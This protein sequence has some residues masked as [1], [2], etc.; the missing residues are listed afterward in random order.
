M[1]AAALWAM[2]RW[3]F[4]AIGVAVAAVLVAVLVELRAQPGEDALVM[5]ADQKL[6]DAVR[7]GDRSVARRLLSLQFSFVDENGKAYDRK[8]FLSALKGM[9]EASAA[10]V[11]V[12]RYGRVA[13]VT[14]HRHSAHDD[15]VF[16]LDIWAKQKGNWRA[17]LM[18][19][20]APATADAAAGS[21]PSA[22][23]SAAATPYDCK[24]PCQTLPYRVR[25]PAEQDIVNAFQAI[26]KAAIAHDADAW[27]KNVADEFVLYGS[28]RAPIPT[29]A[30][31][32]TIERQKADN[33]A[34]TVGEIETMRL[35]V[36]GDGAAMTAM[37]V[38]PD[39][40]RPPYRAARLWVKRGGQWQMAISVQ[41]D[42][43]TPAPA[44]TAS[45]LP[46]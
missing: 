36:Y 20:V 9:A 44:Q 23:P 46:Q 11:K 1:Q 22:L 5:S 32:A 12:R 8:S 29:S 33:H 17:L 26:E 7:A 38:L 15:D 28:G 6:G 3:R 16:F 2:P 27:S 19:D 10:D 45:H 4:G 41:T 21:T 14:G 24:N 13:M 18:Q 34:V 43:K 30:R 31:I 37:H 42:V 40:A 25:S 35:S 39:N